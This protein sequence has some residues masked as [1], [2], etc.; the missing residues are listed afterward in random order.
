MESLR[1]GFSPEQTRWTPCATDTSL[2][3][4]REAEVKFCDYSIVKL[5]NPDFFSESVTTNK[6]TV[7]EC[8]PASETLIPAM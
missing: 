2:V 8:F 4:Y 1:A 6:L 5:E 3:I 7:S